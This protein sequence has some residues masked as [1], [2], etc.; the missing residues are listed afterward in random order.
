MAVSVSQ[1]AVS[2]H[3]RVLREARLVQLHKQAQHHIYSLNPAGL[4]EL[5]FYFES[6]WEGALDAFQKAAE[7]TADQNIAKEETQNE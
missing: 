7:D 1:P 2:Q 4:A 5:R 3:L 6:F